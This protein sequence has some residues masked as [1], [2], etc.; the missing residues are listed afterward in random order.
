MGVST[1]RAATRPP[2]QRAPPRARSPPRQRLRCHVRGALDT[3]LF[4][5]RV[6]CVAVRAAAVCTAAAHT[7]APRHRLRAPPPTRTAVH[8]SAARLHAP[9]PNLLGRATPRPHLRA[10]AAPRP[11]LRARDAPYCTRA[12]CAAT[13]ACAPRHT[14]HAYCAH[15]QAGSL[16]AFARR[17]KCLADVLSA[18]VRGIEKRR[19]ASFPRRA[20]LMSKKDTPAALS[21]SVRRLRLHTVRTSTTLSKR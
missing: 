21:V 16:R 19:W 20:T 11:T 12:C 17:R 14:A 7:L 5:R 15:A 13:Y 9:R 2:T 1:T 18:C 8:T 4:A 3:P 10:R 6:R